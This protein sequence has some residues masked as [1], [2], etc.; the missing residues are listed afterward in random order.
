MSN[1]TRLS[2]DNLTG[3]PMTELPPP[4][5]DVLT[6][7]MRDRNTTHIPRQVLTIDGKQRWFSLHK[8]SLEY[9]LAAVSGITSGEPQG[10]GQVILVEAS[11]GFL[12]LGDP[13]A[14]SWGLLAGRAQ[15]FLRVAW[16]L[17][18]FPG[19]AIAA[20][21]LGINLLADAY[22]GVLGGATGIGRTPERIGS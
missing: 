20:A 15:G 6:G 18:V 10:S 22:A 8:A 11:L 21:V 12:G 5:Q 14:L 9:P 3:L 16:W 17:A 4:W 13:N 19:L 1:L 7:F 2:G